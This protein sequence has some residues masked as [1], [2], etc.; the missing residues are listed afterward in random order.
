MRAYLFVFDPNTF[1]RQFVIDRIDG[2]DDVEN[3]YAF[4]PS[5]LC[6]ISDLEAKELSKVIRTALPDMNFLV[7]RLDQGT[8]GGWLRKSVWDFMSHPEGVKASNS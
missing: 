8:K 5:A 7:T 6:L 1:G 3:W 4:L 2:L